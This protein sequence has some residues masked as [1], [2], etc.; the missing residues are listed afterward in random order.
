MIFGDRNQTKRLLHFA[1]LCWKVAADETKDGKEA[2]IT[3]IWDFEIVPGMTAV[4]CAVKPVEKPAGDFIIM[5]RLAFSEVSICNSK[6]FP[7]VG[8]VIMAGWEESMV[9]KQLE[10]LQLNVS[11]GSDCISKEFEEEEIDDEKQVETDTMK[12]ESLKSFTEV[13]RWEEAAI[14]QDSRSI[15]KCAKSLW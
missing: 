13:M 7:R 3:V 5:S 4:A 6:M 11:D 2:Q 9:A 8:A 14:I 12:D 15:W 10:N 1:L